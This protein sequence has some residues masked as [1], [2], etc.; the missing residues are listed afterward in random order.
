MRNVTIQ[1]PRCLAEFAPAGAKEV[2]S[3]LPETALFGKNTLR[4]VSVRASASARTQRFPSVQKPG[5]AGSE[6]LL[7]NRLIALALAALLLLGAAGCGAAGHGGKLRIV[8]TTFPIY[9]WVRTIL[10]DDTDAELIWLLDSGVDLH[11][12]QA[13]AADL[14]IIADCDVFIYIGGV[15]DAWVDDAL[16]QKRNKS[17]TVV[18][19]MEV[20]GTA[21][22]LEEVPAGAEAE[23]GDGADEYDEHIWLSLQNARVLAAYIGAVLEGKDPENAETY[24]A[25]TEQLNQDLLL[26][27]VAYLKA[28]S[29]AEIQTLVFGDR[30]PFRYLM[31]DYGLDYYAAFAGCS[32]ETEAS[33][34]TVLYLAE[35]VD[36]LG[37]PAVIALEGSDG[38]LAQTVADAAASGPAVLV[39][40]PMQSVT[41]QD[42]AAGKTYINIMN[43][44]LLVLRQALGLD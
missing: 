18:D 25:N 3:F 40:D 29:E 27:D 41:V 26:L 28:A 35:K 5:E 22:S 44:N 20:L 33:F 31:D 38:R 11:S 10:G 37:L 12:Y 9:D 36:E 24:A 23:E 7:R 13:T 8:V 16:A 15:S 21:V 42:A 34:E 2:R 30:F 4:G 43:D 39:M 6:Q 17:M 32:A 19:L 1:N 14:A